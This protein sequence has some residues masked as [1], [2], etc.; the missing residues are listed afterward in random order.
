MSQPVET[1]L[2]P[3]RPD[4]LGL[5]KRIPDCLVGNEV[6]PF[7]GHVQELPNDTLSQ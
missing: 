6:Y 4:H 2:A 5:F 1:L 3:D 7:D